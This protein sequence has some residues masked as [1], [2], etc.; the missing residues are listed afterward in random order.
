MA[1]KVIMS[2]KIQ[3]AT[4]CIDSDSEYCSVTLITSI[5]KGGEG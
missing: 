5:H 2:Q 4:G 1:V 3:D